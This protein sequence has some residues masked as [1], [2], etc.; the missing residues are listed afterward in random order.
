MHILIHLFP[1]QFF[2][3]NSRRTIMKQHRKLKEPF[4]DREYVTLSSFSLIC[5]WLLLQESTPSKLQS[6]NKCMINW[7]WISQCVIFLLQLLIESKNGS[8]FSSCSETTYPWRVITE[9]FTQEIPFSLCCTFV[10]GIWTFRRHDKNFLSHTRHHHRFDS[11]K[12]S[13]ITQAWPFVND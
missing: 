11:K 5:Q 12:N 8:C 6:L 2:T 4:L 9:R 1:R 7:C 13:S 3:R 10:H